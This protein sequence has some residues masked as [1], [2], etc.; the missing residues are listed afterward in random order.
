MF[1]PNMFFLL[2]LPPIIFESGYSLHKVSPCQM[3][4]L[5]VEVLFGTDSAFT[6]LNEAQDNCIKFHY[7]NHQGT[8]SAKFEPLEPRVQ[9]V[10]LVA[11][12]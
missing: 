6:Y 1:R 11:D 5:G 2:L 10:W 9:G 12:N 4:I 3:V 7:I 8:G